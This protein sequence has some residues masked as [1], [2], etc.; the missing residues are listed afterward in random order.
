MKRGITPAQ[1]DGELL[2]DMCIDP[3]TG[4]HTDFWADLILSC[5]TGLPAPVDKSDYDE[6]MQHLESLCSVVSD[7]KQSHAYT[8][9][10][11]EIAIAYRHECLVSYSPLPG[12]ELLLKKWRHWRP[13]NVL[14]LQPCTQRE[15]ELG[16]RQRWLDRLLLHFSPLASQIPNLRVLMGDRDPLKE[17][18]HLFGDTRWRTLRLHVLSLEDGQRTTSEESSTHWSRQRRL[19]TK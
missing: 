14:N 12:V 6:I 3:E 19:P 10:E 5:E 1:Q 8:Q 15:L 16:L 9:V 18:G 7:G 2:R 11:L 4:K 17:Y 13:G